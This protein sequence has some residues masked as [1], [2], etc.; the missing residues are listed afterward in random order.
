[1]RHLLSILFI[2]LFFFFQAEDGIRDAQESRGLGDVYKRQARGCPSV[3]QGNS[4]G[5]VRGAEL[6]GNPSVQAVVGMSVAES[7]PSQAEPQPVGDEDVV[8]AVKEVDDS[9]VIPEALELRTFAQL[10]STSLA[11]MCAS[12]GLTVVDFMCIHEAAQADQVSSSGHWDSLRQQ[13]IN[14][15]LEA[16]NRCCLRIDLDRVVS[17]WARNGSAP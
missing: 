10:D 17:K 12:L 16:L 4:E 1:M 6:G 8:E 3:G 5:E 2:L 14:T 7:T 9:C 13:G 15:G 11:S